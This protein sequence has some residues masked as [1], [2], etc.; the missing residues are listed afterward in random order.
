MT[1][2]L[3]LEGAIEVQRAKG[4]AT[5]SQI[6]YY[7][8]TGHPNR[9]LTA[10]QTISIPTATLWHTLLAAQSGTLSPTLCLGQSYLV[11]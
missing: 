7:C 6:F 10:L 3:L 5:S 1:S 11:S 2:P 9:L 4:H 8:P